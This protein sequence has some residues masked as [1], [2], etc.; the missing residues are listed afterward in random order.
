MKSLFSKVLKPQLNTESKF[1]R[2]L[3]VSK[4]DW[5]R[6]AAQLPPDVEDPI[7]FF[8]EHFYDY[9]VVEPEWFDSAYYLE[10][11]PD[12]EMDGANP[13]VHYLLYG[14]KEGRLAW[15]SSISEG[16]SIISAPERQPEK[17]LKS[18]E[19]PKQKQLPREKQPLSKLAS[20]SSP[21]KVSSTP[22]SSISLN[23]EGSKVENVGVEKIEE[24]VEVQ[25][26]EADTEV[27]VVQASYSP[28]DQRLLKELDNVAISWDQV[29]DELEMPNKSA[30]IEFLLNAPTEGIPKIAGFF[31]PGLYLSI[32]PDIR[33]AKV[34]PLDHFLFH[35]RQEGRMGWLSPDDY[36]TEGG[37][38][39]QSDLKTL[40]L[41]SHDASATGAPVVALEIA[42]R[43]AQKHNIITVILRD[44]VLRE[45]FAEAGVCYLQA[46]AMNN[47]GIMR[48]ILQHLMR[49]YQPDAALLNSVES[50]SCL[51]AA[52]SLGLPTVS[53]LHEFAEYT[54][55]S[56]KMGR[57]LIASDIAV[58]PAQ[59]LKESGLRE[60][61]EM[62]A[63]KMVPNSIQIQPQGY[64]GF[65]GKAQ[66]D[67][68]WSLRQLLKLE[69]EAIVIAGAG[70][71]QPRKGVDWFLE[72]CYYFKQLLQ[73]RGDARAEKLQFVWLGDGFHID[74]IQV[75]IWLQTFMQ[76]TGIRDQCYFPGAV[77]DVQIA[78]AE[79]DIY[80]L[81][82]RLDPFPN[83]AIDALQ[84]DCGMGTFDGSSG[85]A[86]FLVEKKARAVTAPYGDTHELAQQLADNLDILLERD[87]RNLEI[88]KRHLSFERYVE[89]I[90]LTL[91]DAAQ[92]QRDIQQV[93]ANSVIFQQRFNPRFYS[94][95]FDDASNIGTATHFLSLLYKGLVHAKPFPGSDIQALVKDQPYQLGSS[96]AD[97]VER[98]MQQ[99]VEDMPVTVLRG[100]GNKPYAGKIALQFHIYYNDLIPE[101][102]SYFKTLADHDVDIFVSHVNELTSEEKTLLK[103]TVSGELYCLPVGNEGRDVYPFHQLFVAKIVD[104]Y[105]VVGH[106]HT[107]KSRDS[108]GGVGE[109]WRRYLLGNLAGSPPASQEIL[110]LFEDEKVGLVFA[111][112]PH[113][114]DECAN[115]EYI[116]KLLAPLGYAKRNRYHDFPLGTMFWARTEALKS[117][118]YLDLATFKLSEPI[119]YDGSVLH[120]FERVIPQL[121]QEAGFTVKRVYTP[122]TYW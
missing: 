7:E 119:P 56:G 100:A 92:R 3:A 67:N 31:D 96:F 94:L 115:G 50:Y 117:L 38:E 99:V 35:G 9:P 20:S 49:K 109:R 22:Q 36:I 113:C 45:S 77:D 62:W 103:E 85:I 54:R 76:K 71:V 79:A 43:L 97:Y 88:C 69:D 121:V 39:Y 23:V 107:K 66:K 60:L 41:V 83:V 101:Y 8:L 25:D 58:Y 51:A 86:D 44:G 48:L 120:A 30:A 55:P 116:E 18:Q 84:A 104:N 28:R 80:L 29:I 33:L 63:S 37:R 2:L 106:F 89:Q 70:H 32:Y 122:N 11:N 46:P 87:G 16:Q 72:T 34:N 108:G 24:N 17:S 110:G 112:D 82:S 19:P 42:K 98:A 47:P 27:N 93:I 10:T 78:L 14:K 95:D 111:E 5:Q 6:Y 21:G 59:S 114:I 81:T 57:T 73:K 90:E 13:L 68:D 26:V 4:V 1:K 74:D 52:A 118:T 64:L 105:D 102:C 75:S 61:H 65:N 40:L 53:L 91:E 15:P 12:V